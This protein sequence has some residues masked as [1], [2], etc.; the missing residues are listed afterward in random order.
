MNMYRADGFVTDSA[1]RAWHELV[2][3]VLLSFFGQAKGICVYCFP[4]IPIKEG[5]ELKS[6][7][8][9]EETHKAG[10]ADDTVKKASTFL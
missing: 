4:Y 5:V 7:Q 1:D 6:S 8:Q 3:E 10:E 9:E 2:P